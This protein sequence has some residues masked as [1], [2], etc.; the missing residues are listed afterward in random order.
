MGKVTIIPAQET[1]A[2]QKA[3]TRKLRVAAYVRVSTLSDEQEDSFE[4]QKKHYEEL[5]GSNPRWDLVKIYADQASGLN[6]KK[7]TQFNT[8]M[9]D[10]KCHKFDVLYVKSI[11]RFARNTITTLT[12]I[13]ELNSYGIKT[14][15]E[16]ENLVS[17]DPS[18]NIMLSLVASMAESESLSIS[19]N[20]NLGLQYKYS[21]G[22]WSAN[23]TNFL[24]YDKLP[25]GTIAINEEQAETVREIFSG[26]LSGM[27]LEH[28]AKVLTDEGR[29]TGTGA[30]KWTKT[31]LQRILSNIKYS[32]DVI[33]GLTKTIDVINK[34]RVI[35]NGVAPQY[36]IDNGIP[37][38]VTKQVYLIAKG[39]LARRERQFI[40]EGSAKGPLIYQGKFPFTRK[41]VCPVCGKYYN[42][43]NARGEYVWECFGRIHG[44]CKAEI[45][46][47]EELCGVILNAAQALWDLKPEIRMNKIPLLSSKDS[48]DQM[49]NAAALYMENVFAKRTHAFLSC[50]RP[51]EYKPEIVRDLVEKIN[52]SE[53]EFVISFYG[54]EA[55]RIG[56]TYPGRR[57]NMTGRK[58]KRS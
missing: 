39:E 11:S 4:N 41:I 10:A 46:K 34:K 7:R 6:T 31:G 33:Q 9:R 12:A 1:L 16:K 56:R 2:E 32:G 51:V 55:I 52:I 15:F 38:I 27:S 49:V 13:R 14:I 30:V 25:D 29:K 28:L 45:I 47:E 44:I 3:E 5:V 23:F 18:T 40:D 19:E 37:A 8:M 26:F 20:V 35:N 58:L 24:G 42:H 54:T 22:E 50:D 17:T 57:N 21:R 43:R 53:D 36:F 48:E